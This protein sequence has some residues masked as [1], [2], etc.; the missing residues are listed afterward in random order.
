LLTTLKKTILQPTSEKPGTE[1][2]E[3]YI[4]SHTANV[5]VIS[6]FKCMVLKF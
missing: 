1:L 6:R 3:A 2:R 5:L 4:N